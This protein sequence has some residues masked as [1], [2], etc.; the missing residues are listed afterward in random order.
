MNNEIPQHF[1]DVFPSEKQEARNRL[2]RL[3]DEL[4]N[5]PDSF[6][7]VGW[8]YQYDF[9]YMSPTLEKVLGHPHHK[10]FHEGVVYFQSITP[11]H[12]VNHIF[13]YL[14]TFVERLE[15]HPLHIGAPLYASVQAALVNLEGEEVPIVHTSAFIDCKAAQPNSYLILASWMDTRNKTQDQVQDA[16]DCTAKIL[17]EAK[18]IYLSLLP[19][20]SFFTNL[21]QKVTARERE[22]AVL[23]SQGYSTRAIGEKLRISFNTVESHRKNLLEKFCARNTAELVSKASKVLW[24]QKK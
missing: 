8:L 23:L 11:H 15:S 4:E 12:L 6:C 17:L 21:R 22:V 7:G 24:L 9:L 13:G 19:D 18:E 1:I 14:H 3:L 20:H 16:V 5:I 10:F 2:G